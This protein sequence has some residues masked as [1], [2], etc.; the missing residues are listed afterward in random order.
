MR[1][2]TIGGGMIKAFVTQNK[3]PILTSH[4]LMRAV[5]LS[6]MAANNAAFRQ[7]VL[8]HPAVKHCLAALEVSAHLQ[9]ERASYNRVYLFHWIFMGWME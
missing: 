4:T 9:Q 7:L 8:G 2:H 1:L 6:W 5:V 3:L